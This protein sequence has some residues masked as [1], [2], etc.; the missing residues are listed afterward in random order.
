MQIPDPQ[1]PKLARPLSPVERQDSIPKIQRP[2][3][4][5]TVL[6]TAGAYSGNEIATLTDD[7]NALHTAKV[8]ELLNMDKV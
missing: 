8:N 4:V 1:I 7:Q 2:A 6:T 5:N 3:E